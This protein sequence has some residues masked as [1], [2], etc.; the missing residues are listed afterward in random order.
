MRR[1]KGRNLRC[2]V[3]GGD[4]GARDETKNCLMANRMVYE[5]RLIP[6]CEQRHGNHTYGAARK[7]PKA[8]RD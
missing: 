7:C 2:T 8:A 1:K 3:D 4:G 5:S 6:S